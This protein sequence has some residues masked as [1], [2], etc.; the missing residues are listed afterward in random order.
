VTAGTTS[1]LVTTGQAMPT[2]T[3]PTN[4]CWD[5]KGYYSGDGG[6]GTQYYTAKGKPKVSTSPFTANTTL[7]AKWTRATAT[8]HM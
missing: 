5:F 4:T 6:T 8:V 7:H 1:A 3:P 2:I